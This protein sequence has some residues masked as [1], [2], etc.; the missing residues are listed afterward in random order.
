[1]IALV[2]GLGNLLIGMAYSG[3]GLLSLWEAISQYRWRGLSRFGLGFSLM[4][5]SCGPH[6]LVHGW[7]VLREGGASMPMLEVTLIGL[8]AGVVFCLLRIEAMLGRRGDRTIA[9]P[10]RTLAL[11]ATAFFVVVGWLAGGA[12]DAPLSAD[13]AMCTPTGMRYAAA[14]LLPVNSVAS[15]GLLC[16]VFVTVTYSLVGW[17]LFET[18]VRRYAV[19]QQWSL[20]GLALTAVFPTCAAWSMPS[21]SAAA[22]RCCRSTCSAYSLRFISCGSSGV[23]TRTPWSTGIVVHSPAWQ[24]P[25]SALRLGAARILDA[26]RP[27]A[28]PVNRLLSP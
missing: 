18:Q 7:H 3:L 19:G 23:F 17:Y 28:A 21:A 13:Q 26:L 10:L 1:M 9:M 14:G 16:N 24:E 12:L 5:A 4:A 6:H 8:P 20:S 2:I 25:P 22:G 27:R 11:L 15:L